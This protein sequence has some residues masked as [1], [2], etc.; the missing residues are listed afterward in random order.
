MCDCAFVGQRY[1]CLCTCVLHSS[2]R[3]FIC[4]SLI[5]MPSVHLLET[6][7]QLILDLDYDY[8]YGFCVLFI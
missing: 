3:T 6:I 4:R 2:T 7:S 5:S 1:D 8:D